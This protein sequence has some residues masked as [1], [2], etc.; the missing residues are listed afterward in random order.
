MGC[1]VPGCE[2]MDENG[3]G[4][5]DINSSEEGTWW[6]HVCD[7]GHSWDS[8]LQIDTCWLC[9]EACISTMDLETADAMGRKLQTENIPEKLT[10]DVELEVQ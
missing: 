2:N 9:G 5:D 1:E 8:M 3:I 10:E 7:C 6:V 4:L